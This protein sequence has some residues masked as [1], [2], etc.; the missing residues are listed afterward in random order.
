MLSSFVDVLFFFFTGICQ[1]A[2]AV[3]IM[4][5]AYILH[6]WAMPFLSREN[7]PQSFFDIVNK[8]P[9]EVSDDDDAMKL[10][11]LN[12]ASSRMGCFCTLNSTRMV[13]CS[14]EI[15]RYKRWP[16]RASLG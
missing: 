12:F 4:F 6:T 16:S 13:A 1:A 5:A 9:G 7:I 14:C 10:G 2:M 8:D 15:R 3:A 11:N